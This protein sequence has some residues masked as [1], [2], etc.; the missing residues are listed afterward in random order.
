[1]F[2]NKVAPDS[3][4]VLI[5][6]EYYT[7]SKQRSNRPAFVRWLSNHLGRYNT[8]PWLAGLPLLFF[9]GSSPGTPGSNS[10]RNSPRIPGGSF[11][12]GNILAC[13]GWGGS[14]CRG[15][16]YRREYGCGCPMA[17]SARTCDCS[18]GGSSRHVAPGIGRGHYGKH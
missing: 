1:M 17:G 14:S 5:E 13:V 7:V 3:T 2:T 15:N 4:Q 12:Q 10:W 11:R 18:H 6:I 16:T 9:K 8:N